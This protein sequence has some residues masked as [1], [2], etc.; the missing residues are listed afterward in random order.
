MLNL[1]ITLTVTA[2]VVA[3]WSRWGFRVMGMLSAFLTPAE[4]AHQRVNI[5]RRQ[6]D[7]YKALL[8]EA[9][10]RELEGATL[11]RETLESDDELARAYLAQL[12]TRNRKVV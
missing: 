3:F 1:A 8:R 12:E 2:I 10:W 5:N 7:G 11:L 6:R 9:E 4:P